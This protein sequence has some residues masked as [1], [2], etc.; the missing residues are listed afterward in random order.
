MLDKLGPTYPH[1]LRSEVPVWGLGAGG[2][3]PELLGAGRS[4]D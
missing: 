4:D 2:G 1:A 3:R